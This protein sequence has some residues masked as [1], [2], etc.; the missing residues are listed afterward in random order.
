MVC[1]TVP[2]SIILNDP[3]PKFQAPS[4][5][6]LFNAEYLRNGTRYKHNYNEIPNIRP[7]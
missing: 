3:K 5:H 1:P 2:F 4:I 7:Y 6:P